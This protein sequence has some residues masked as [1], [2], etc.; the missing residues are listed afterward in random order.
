MA[1][2]RLQAHRLT[3][4]NEEPASSR[5]FGSRSS[6]GKSSKLELPM[7]KA[8]P[9]IPSPRST[10]SDELVMPSLSFREI[11]KVRDQAEAQGPSSKSMPVSSF[12][13]DF[14]T[15]RDQ[16]ELLKLKDL[17]Q[18][19]RRCGVD[20]YDEL[21]RS[22]TKSTQAE[23][24]V[25]SVPSGTASEQRAEMERAFAHLELDFDV[26]FENIANITFSRPSR[27]PSRRTSDDDFMPMMPQAFGLGF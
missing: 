15:R 6:K 8:K 17:A 13:G 18:H 3:L 25:P 10:K 9:D 11:A 4:V 5:S 23:T 14:R 21:E 16:L 1:R 26:A 2:A 12:R 24:E 19:Y 7:L 27:G 22:D 20:S